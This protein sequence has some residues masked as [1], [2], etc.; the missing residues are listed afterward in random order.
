MS[1]NEVTCSRWQSGIN[2]SHVSFSCC[3]TCRT[4]CA[5]SSCI[6]GVILR[7]QTPPGSDATMELRFT[8]DWRRVRCLDPD[9]DT[10]LLEDMEAEL[11]SGL[12]RSIPT[13]N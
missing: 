13:A 6:S 11:R 10:A 2:D 1:R 3:A 12:R 7:E 8:R 4:R 9:A 5:T